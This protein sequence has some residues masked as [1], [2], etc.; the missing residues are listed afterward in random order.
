MKPHLQTEATIQAEFYH[1]CRLL[2]LTC[3]LEYTTPVGRLDAVVFAEGLSAIIAGVE[4][5]RPRTHS[6]TRRNEV[7]LENSRQLQ[8]YRSTGITMFTLIRFEDA[9]RL[10]RLIKDMLQSATAEPTSLD[11]VHSTE[12]PKRRR[13]VRYVE[14]DEMLL[15]R[16]VE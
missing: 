6:G 5:K 16:S 11:R 3:V 1:Q 15:I 4:C 10:A 9:E 14:P 8:R 13:R 12:R 2:G 7:A